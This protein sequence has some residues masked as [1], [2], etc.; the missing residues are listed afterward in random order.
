MANDGDGPYELEPDDPDAPAEQVDQSASSQP[1][2]DAVPT[3]PLLD[4]LDAHADP[5][6]DPEGERRL[7]H[8]PTDV[9]HKAP[10]TPL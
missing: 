4:D 2:G 9:E 1:S 5:E 10:P 7:T 6:H 8:Q 3:E